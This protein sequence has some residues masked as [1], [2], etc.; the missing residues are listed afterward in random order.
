MIKKSRR[1]PCLI[2]IAYPYVIYIKEK[3]EICGHCDG[4]RLTEEEFL[5]SIPHV[6]WSVNNLKIM[7]LYEKAR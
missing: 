7:E 2:C 4:K 3:K 1:F 5:N 6:G